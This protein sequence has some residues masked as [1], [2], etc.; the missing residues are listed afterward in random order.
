MSF[1][2]ILYHQNC[3]GKIERNTN[4]ILRGEILFASCW[5]IKLSNCK[6][7][8]ERRKSSTNFFNRQTDWQT[9]RLTDRQTKWTREAPA[10]AFT[11]LTF[12]YRYPNIVQKLV[13]TNIWQYGVTTIVKMFCY[14]N[15][16]NIFC[17]SKGKGDSFIYTITYV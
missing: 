8:G 4:W 17:V 10:R 6:R 2:L 5:F 1:I 13:K 15:I 7:F 16:S 3:G 12:T 11:L 9:D 14:S